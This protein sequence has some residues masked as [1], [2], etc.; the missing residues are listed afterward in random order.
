MRSGF[1]DVIAKKS[2]AAV[3]F[4][5]EIAL[6]RLGLRKEFDATIFPYFSR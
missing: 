6:I 2:A 3:E 4:E 1:L 5:V